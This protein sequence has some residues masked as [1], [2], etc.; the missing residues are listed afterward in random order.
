MILFLGFKGCKNEI[1]EETPNI[2][3]SLRFST[4]GNTQ[5]L[6]WTVE[7]RS[8]VST[9]IFKEGDI[10]NYE[11]RHTSSGKK[12]KSDEKE[13]KDIILEPDGIYETTIEF[14]DLVIGHY[15]TTFWANWNEDM[16]SSMTIQ[17]VVEK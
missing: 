14:Q 2:Y 10:L 4:T 3:V 6:I 17:F 15:E 13:T 11:I 8:K 9:V 16:K 5:S 1:E 12:Y 7:N